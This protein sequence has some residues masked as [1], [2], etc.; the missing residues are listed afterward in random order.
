MQDQL[1]FVFLP[2]QDDIIRGWH[3][4]LTASSSPFKFH[5]AENQADA[6]ALIAGA[7]A[8]YGEVTPEL[9]SRASKLKWLQAPY[10][11][12]PEGFFPDFLQQH[13]LVLTNFRGIYSDHIAVHVMAYILGF[14]RGLHYYLPRQFK[15]EW[16]PEP[17]DTGVI[18]LPGKTVL[19]VG[20]GGIGSEL[21][22]L[23]AAF[24]LRVIG[25]DARRTEP[26]QYVQRVAAAGELDQLLPEADF[27][28]VTVP[29]TPATRLMF[30]R[31]RFRAMKSSAFFIN[32]GRGGTTSIADLIEALN[33]GDLAG[34]GLDV[35]EDE[36]LLPE[37][38]LWR[39]PNLLI[40]P[41][42]ASYG[43]DLDERRFAI[44]RDNCERFASGKPLHNVV[45]KVQGF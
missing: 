13:K 3:H 9:L 16:N 42:M 29:L 24:G 45:D 7:D 33:A 25:V 44:I 38:P 18:P 34:A 37:H 35:F 15:H 22:R 36:P 40:T 12:P 30:K 6:L 41:H 23:C 39:T 2:P 5:L 31:D 14:A 26:V 4:R 27:L 19:I 20:V 1:S 17:L 10:A 28:V 21:A 43:P 32:V 11:A 8:A